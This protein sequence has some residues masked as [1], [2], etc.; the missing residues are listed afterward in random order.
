[1]QF[2]RRWRSWSCCGLGGWVGLGL[3]IGLAVWIGGGIWP[4]ASAQPDDSE[5]VAGESRTASSASA[6]KQ[7]KSEPFDPQRIAAAGIRR[8]ESKHLILYTDL[9]PD[10]ELDA[11]PEVFDQAFEPFCSYFALDPDKHAQWRMTGR[12]M[13]DPERFRRAGLLPAD[14]PKFAH[15]FTKSYDFWI[16]EQP[17][18]Y[19]RRHLMLHEGV[20]G[21]M[22][23]LLGSCGPTWYM[24]GVAELLATHSWKQGQLL[25]KY[26]PRSSEEVPMWGRI[27]IVRDAVQQRGLLSLEELIRLVPQIAG[28]NE[29]YGWCWA[30]AAFLDNHPRYQSAFRQMVAWVRDSRFTER[31][32]SLLGENRSLL[33]EEW[34]LFVDEICYGYDFSRAAVQLQPGRPIPP[35]GAKVQVLAD[36]GWQS[37]TWLV[38]AGRTYLLMASGRYQV[39]DKPKIWW[40]EPNGVSIQYYRG[41]PLGM[42]LAAVR[43]EPQEAKDLLQPQR[44]GSASESDFSQRW[45][46]SDVSAGQP[47]GSLRAMFGFA[48]LV[49]PAGPTPKHPGGRAN[50]LVDRSSQQ[51]RTGLLE[52]IPIGLQAKLTPPVSGTLYFRINESPAQL[53]DNAGAL[54]V[55]IKLE[56]Q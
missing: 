47:S 7:P 52:P 21:L 36:R 48:G 27:K 35:E 22:L 1:M 29:L 38:E 30:L 12:L 46:F 43:P 20:H 53:Y 4:G 28:E 37:S 54:V 31:F 40:C 55:Y 19:Y 56:K 33:N 24:E 5:A 26:L 51:A 3:C 11:L 23:T 8:L 42:L 13:R 50:G 41:R 49:Q 6:A 25:V 15:G 10:S 34:K 2:G 45:F 18:A 16:Y 14:L 32:F 44:T 17:S 9:P 39:A